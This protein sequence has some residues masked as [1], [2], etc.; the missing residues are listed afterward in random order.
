MSDIPNYIASIYKALSDEN[1]VRIL[2]Q[3]GGR[4]RTV[5]RTV[6]EIGLP[7]PLFSHHLRILR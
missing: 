1:R 6:E 5:N 4:S 2:F 3:L 7:Q